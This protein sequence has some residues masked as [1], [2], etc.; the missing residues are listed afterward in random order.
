MYSACKLNP[1]RPQQPACGGARQRGRFAGVTVGVIGGAG[2]RGSTPAVPVG[3][4]DRRG[5]R[6]HRSA[7]STC[8]R[9]AIQSAKQSPGDRRPT[10]RV[11]RVESG[12]PPAWGPSSARASRHSSTTTS[13]CQPIELSQ[14]I[15]PRPIRSPKASSCS[16]RLG[17]PAAAGRRRRRLRG[18]LGRRASGSWLPIR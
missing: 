17:P 2:R 14:A 1:R 12:R 16:R 4:G 6:R 5:S 18:F 7:S 15:E 11:R 13:I 8:A 3:G 10:G 9:H